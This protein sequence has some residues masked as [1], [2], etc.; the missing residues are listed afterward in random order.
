MLYDGKVDLAKC[1]K[2]DVN[3]VRLFGL[4][5]YSKSFKR[6][7]MVA[8]GIQMKGIRQSGKFTSVLIMR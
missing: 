3:K 4:K 8:V 2:L 1:E 5:S 7:I 6:F